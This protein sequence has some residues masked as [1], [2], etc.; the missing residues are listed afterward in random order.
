MAK[1]VEKKDEKIIKEEELNKLKEELTKYIDES[2]DE[3][4]IKKIDNANKSVLREKSK[5]I[6]SKN[7]LITFLLLVIVSLLYIMNSEGYFLRYVKNSNEKNSNNQ[8]VVT[9]TNSSSNDNEPVTNEPVITLDDLKKEYGYLLD[10]I[11]INTNSNYYEDFVK[12]ELS[13]NSI[14]FHSTTPQCGNFL[15]GKITGRRANM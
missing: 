2:I 8:S 10:N 5:K 12:H 14:P 3:T 13:E 7:I 9:P 1:K 11:I 6:L 4:F 15:S